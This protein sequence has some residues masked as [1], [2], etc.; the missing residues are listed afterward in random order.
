MR[1]WAVDPWVVVGLMLVHW[2]TKS[3]SEVG[4]VVEPLFLDPALDGWWIST[5]TSGWK[6]WGVPKL[7]LAYWWIGLDPDLAG[8]GD[9]DISELMLVCWWALAQGFQGWYQPA[10]GKSQGL[11]CPSASVISLVF[12]TGSWGPLLQGPRCPKAGVSHL[13]G[14]VG[15]RGCWLRNP[16]CPSTRNGLFLFRAKDWGVLGMMAACWWVGSESRS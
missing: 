8:W 1:H 3:C 13:V 16:R 14:G 15:S 4:S 6:F 5:D 10:S 2:G 11:G 7:V 12:G 9:Q